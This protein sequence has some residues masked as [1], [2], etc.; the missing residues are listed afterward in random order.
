MKYAIA[1]QQTGQYLHEKSWTNT[2]LKESAPARYLWE[3]SEI[4]ALEQLLHNL[5]IGGPEATEN[6]VYI[7]V[8]MSEE[9]YKEMLAEEPY[10]GVLRS[11]IQ[12]SEEP[13]GIQ[14]EQRIY[15]WW[16]FRKIEK[17]INTWSKSV[18]VVKR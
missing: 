2:E 10:C 13:I 7:M 8:E 18:K 9:T 1:N 5:K 14:S 6:P 4:H 3:R 11:E 16:Y 15:F 12:D 17:L